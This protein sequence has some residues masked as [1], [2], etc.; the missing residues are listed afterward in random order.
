MDFKR[1]RIK[2]G[3]TQ[4]DVAKEI[5]VSLAAYRLWELGGGKPNEQNMLKLKGLFS[6]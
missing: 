4:I 6:K 2:I 1:E 5:G 3:L